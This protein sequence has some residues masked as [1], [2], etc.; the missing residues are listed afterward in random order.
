MCVEKVKDHSELRIMEDEVSKE[1]VNSMPQYI[2]KIV[3][4]RNS[5]NGKRI[6]IFAVPIIY[7]LWLGIIIAVLHTPVATS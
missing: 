2:E 6:A 1:S 3:R 5:H 7:L 4:F